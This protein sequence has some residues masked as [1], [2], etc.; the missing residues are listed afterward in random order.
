MQKY[1]DTKEVM[2][3]LGMSSATVY[4]LITQKKLPAVKIGGKWKISIEELDELLQEQ[5]K[6]MKD[7]KT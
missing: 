2:E 7:K 3:I 1:I 6:K 4:R 5:R